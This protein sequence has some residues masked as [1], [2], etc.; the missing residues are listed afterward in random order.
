MG[1]Q[2][3]EDFY[4]VQGEGFDTGCPAY[5]IRLKGCNLTCGCSPKFVS[6][7]KKRGKGNTD[8]GSFQ[9]DLHAEG[10]ATWTCDT[11]PVWLFG[12]EKDDDYLYNRWADQGILD[13]VYSGLVHLIWTG[14]EPTL[15]QHQR[16]I[17]DQLNYLVAMRKLDSSSNKPVQEI[18]NELETNG[19]LELTT[20]MQMWMDRINCS[21]KLSNTGLPLEKRRNIEAI[22][23]IK[24]HEGG[25]FKFVI[26]SE[27][28]VE[29]MF[30]D[31]INPCGIHLSQV[32]CMPGLDDQENFHERTRFV[33]EMA[34]KYKFRGLTRMHVSA[35]DK[36]TGV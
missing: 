35:W 30:D 36:T 15:P 32:C 20:E 1:L 5:F 19:T 27:E 22:E 18:Y 25:T 33:M 4:S 21:A 9:G 10:K 6:D 26:S 11:V 3:A 16:A 13:D 23:Q 12:E 28:D 8:S 14:G 24:N 17:V 34:K 2:I 7:I 29:E 31:F